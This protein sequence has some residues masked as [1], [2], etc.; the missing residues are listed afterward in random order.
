MPQEYDLSW[1]ML[2][3]PCEGLCCPG[4]GGGGCVVPTS[5]RPA[6][7]MARVA[8]SAASICLLQNACSVCYPA[9]L[10]PSP[11]GLHAVPPHC[12][13]VSFQ[14]AAGAVSSVNIAPRLAPFPL[15]SFLLSV[16]LSCMSTY[17][18]LSTDSFNS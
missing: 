1:R 17:Y 2:S 4:R 18:V 12:V 7:S 3:C 9:P 14:Q 11:R 15:L 10:V 13:V 5:I 16:F 6:W 8:L